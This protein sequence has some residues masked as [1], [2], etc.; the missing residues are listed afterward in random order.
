METTLTTGQPAARPGADR[1]GTGAVGAGSGDA[2]PGSQSAAGSRPDGEMG[3]SVD[4]KQAVDST[5]ANVVSQWPCDIARKNHCDTTVSSPKKPVCDSTV[6]EVVNLSEIRKK[7]D[8]KAARD[9]TVAKGKKRSV[10][11]AEP[12]P[13]PKAIPG[14]EWRRQGT[15]WTLL[16]SWYETDGAGSR[17]R[18]REYIQHYSATAL[19][20]AET[21]REAL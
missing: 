7:R 3:A 14:H 4:H 16:R 5:V 1:L 8:E 2:D 10:S 13:K 12:A 11:K 15:G 9:S 18:R 21:L 20:R 19:R 17:V 6:A